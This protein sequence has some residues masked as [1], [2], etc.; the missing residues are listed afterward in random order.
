[1]ISAPDPAVPRAA[2]CSQMS[3]CVFQVYVAQR[4]LYKAGTSL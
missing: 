4:S 3:K 1:M 2:T